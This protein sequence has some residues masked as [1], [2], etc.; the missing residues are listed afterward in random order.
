L[1]EVERGYLRKVV[2]RLIPLLFMGILLGYIDRANIAYAALQMNRDLNLTPTAYGWAA[3][4]FFL[5]Y[6]V[7][8]IPGT[9]ALGKLGARVWMS[10]L[11][12][13]WAVLAI[14]M[15]LV[16][17]APIFF[18]LRFLLGVAEAG[19]FPGTILYMNYWVPRAHRARIGSRFM[20]AVPLAMVVAGPVSGLV[21]QAGGPGGL[22]GWRWMFLVE[23]LPCLPLAALLAWLLVDRPEKAQW[24]TQAEK[25][26]IAA[27]RAAEETE[28]AAVSVKQ[29]WRA[30]LDARL[31]LLCTVTFGGPAVATGVTFWLPQVMAGFGLSIRETGFLS[32][33]PFA[34]AGAAMWVWGGHSDRTGERRW[35]LALPLFA[36]A[37]GLGGSLLAAEPAIKFVLLLV[38]S[39][40]MFSYLPVAWAASHQLF[41]GKVAPVGYAIISMSGALAGL[42]APSVLGMLRQATGNSDTGVAALAGIAV[43]AGLGGLAFGAVSTARARA[44]S[45][46]AA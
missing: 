14:V 5:G 37:A 34:V 19:F 13:C 18:L 10:F 22:A 6:F 24:L 25:D 12:A 1:G 35:H 33:L 2:L 27:D 28:K 45:A 17:S 26:F 30:L 20:I 29:G 32:A 7:F 15:A 40:G 46:A 4:L 43:L 41:R 44:G 42:V 11:V 38:A 3:G 8:E 23:G 36:A 39:L 16:D 9:M 21:M 31:A